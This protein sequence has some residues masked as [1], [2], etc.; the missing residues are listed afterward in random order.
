MAVCTSAPA[1]VHG[2]E[3]MDSSGDHT[4]PH[5]SAVRCRVCLPVGVYTMM[6]LI[7]LPPQKS[8]LGRLFKFDLGYHVVHQRIN[9]W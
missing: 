9:C 1:S 6:L 4:G 2:A 5:H 3:S 7:Q 8:A